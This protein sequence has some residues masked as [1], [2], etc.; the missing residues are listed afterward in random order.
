VFA[1]SSQFIGVN[2]IA[3]GVPGLLVVLTTFVVNLRHSLYSVSL[4][5]H[6]RN[7]PQRWLIPLGFLL[8]DEAYAVTI[9]H[10]D[11]GGP[12][13]YKHWFFLGAGLSMYLNWQLVTLIGVIAGSQVPNPEQW[14]LDFAMIVTFIG[15]LAPIVTSKP[16]VASVA[17][18]GITSVL[19]NGLP[20]KLGLIVAALLGIAAGFVTEL[21]LPSPDKP[22]VL[23]EVA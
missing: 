15:I 20:N 16:M 3:A 18:A 10:Y 2:M 5:P 8:T 12:S 19:A 22:V 6:V 9:M 21:L 4:G 23:E 7:L 17:V 13:E 11:R 14:G 1:G